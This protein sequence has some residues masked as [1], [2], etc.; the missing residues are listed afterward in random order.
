MRFGLAAKTH[1]ANL[2]QTADSDQSRSGI[3]SSISSAIRQIER[4]LSELYTSICAE[5]PPRSS[6]SELEEVRALIE[7]RRVRFDIFPSMLFSDPAW[8]ILLELYARHLEHRP[9]N[10]SRLSSALPV[11]ATTTLRWLD[12]LHEEGLITRRGDE[13]HA[14][15]I[16]VELSQ[17]GRSL[18]ERY[19]QACRNA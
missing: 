16:W 7:A 14:K 12:R 6:R 2:D 19:L 10:I 17:Y 4:G 13:H 3:E 8:D 9:A 5:P 15:R 18:M 1:M 11:P